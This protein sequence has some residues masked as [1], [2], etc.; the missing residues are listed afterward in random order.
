MS[1]I[2]RWLTATFAIVFLVLMGG[3]AWFYRAQEYHLRAGAEENLQAIS[4]LKAAQIAAWRAERL[5]DATEIVDRYFT[6]EVI[7]RWMVTP[8]AESTK[9]ILSWF[10]GLQIYYK[11]HDVLIADASGQRRLSLTG[12][13]GP[14]HVETLKAVETALRERR[15]VLT[16]LHQEPADQAPYAEAIAPIFSEIGQASEPLGALILQI[17]AR[18]SLYPLIEFWPTPSR[19]AETLIV[20]RDGDGV[21]FLNELRHQKETALNLRIPLSQ[22]D[23]PAVMAVLGKEGVVEGKDYR[24]VE[25][26][27]A[28]RAIPDSPWFLVTK[29]DKTEILASW[30]L[31]SQ[32]ILI[33]ILGLMAAMAATVGMAWQHYTKEHYRALYQSQEALKESEAK[34][35]NLFENMT[36]EVRLWQL[37]RDQNGQIK[38]WRL[39]DAN[40]PALRT[41]GRTLDQIKGKSTD[42][43]SGF[44]ATDHDM[45]VVEKIMTEGVPL[46]FEEYFP[47]TD[48]HFRFTSVPLG[49]YFITTGADITGIKKAQE[50][51]RRAH[52]EL[53]IRVEERTRDLARANEELRRLSSRLMTAQEDE[54]KRIASD[55]H[56]TIG[57]CLVGVKYKV[58]SALQEIRKIP[59]AAAES[60]DSI[61]PRIHEAID[62]CRRIQLDLR[63]SMIDDLGL[64]PTLSWF[65]RTFEQTYRGIR[66]EQKIDIADVDIPDP[67]KIVVFRVTQ[68]AMN[69]I[70]RH[71]KADLVRFSLRKLD[72]RMELVLEDNG[73]GFSLEEVHSRRTTVKGLGLTS[74]R[75]RAELSGG[76]FDIQSADGKGTILIAVWPL[77]K[78]G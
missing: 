45:P 12:R 64:L 1:G 66:I 7:A 54:R 19:S 65:C 18:Q 74:M 24:G 63:P 44:G 26:L 29:V 39:V 59:E 43:I 62:E 50:E 34:Y 67:L 10:H 41:W 27:S 23:L 78:K 77:C 72:D 30:R 8:Q 76:S 16:D 40:P 49:D 70:A 58:E 47:G 13:K 71:S 52:D 4:R 36:E 31:Q 17:D 42:E 3:G 21:L 11:Y 5:A 20:R 53:G 38:T 55:L 35:R 57:S 75:E 9:Q 14:L 22:K 6:D 68:E 56:D 28:L 37:V 32:L 48:K 69:N 15:S 73:R 61:I 46:S 2:P 33:L 60:L 25:V 51:L